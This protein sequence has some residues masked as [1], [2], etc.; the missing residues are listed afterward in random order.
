MVINSLTFSPAS[1][2]SGKQVTIKAIYTVNMPAIQ[3]VTIKYAGS[4]NIKVI[5]WSPQSRTIGP[6]N[7]IRCED[8]VTVQTGSGILGNITLTL[9]GGGSSDSL[10]S[11]IGVDAGHSLSVITLIAG[12]DP[13]FRAKT[14]DHV[15]KLL[16]SSGFNYDKSLRIWKIN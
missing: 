12:N 10:T 4:A 8:N 7:S 6:G 3:A 13:A 9:S 2:A 11:T 16:K 15:R 14:K 1:V 5:G